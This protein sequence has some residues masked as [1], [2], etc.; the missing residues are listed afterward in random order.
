MFSY[1]LYVRVSDVYPFEFVASGRET[2]IQLGEKVNFYT[3]GK[4]LGLPFM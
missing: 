4:Y 2:H 3:A 1:T